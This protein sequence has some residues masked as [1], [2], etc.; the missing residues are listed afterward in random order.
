[1]LIKLQQLYD[2]MLDDSLQKLAWIDPPLASLPGA[3]HTTANLLLRRANLPV[4][5]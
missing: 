4:I 5:C 3:V 1:M 2:E